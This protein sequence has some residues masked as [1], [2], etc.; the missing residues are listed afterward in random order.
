MQTTAPSQILPSYQFDTG[1]TTAIPSVVSCMRTI[2]AEAKAGGLDVMQLCRESK[3]VSEEEAAP[4]MQKLHDAAVLLFLQWQ[5]ARQ[6][7]LCHSV[8]ALARLFNG[9]TK[10]ARELHDKYDLF[11]RRHI[12]QLAEAL[13]DIDYHGAFDPCEVAAHMDTAAQAHTHE[14]AWAWVVLP[15]FARQQ[16]G[17]IL[18]TK[19]DI[20]GIRNPVVV[21]QPFFLAGMCTLFH[22]HGQ[23]WAF[24]RPL[25]RKDGDNSHLNSLWMPR[26]ADNPFPLNLLELAEYTNHGVAIVPPRLIHG[27]SRKRCEPRDIP[28]MKAL[29]ADPERCQRFIAETRFGELA[30]LHIYC[31]HVPLVHQFDDCPLVQAEEEFFIEYDMIVFDHYQESVWCGGGGS[32]PLRMMSFGT[33]GEHCGACFIEDDPRKENL[34]PELV[35]QWFVKS[36]APS[37]IRYQSPTHD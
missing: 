27:I 22:T 33:T 8:L 10:D 28:T 34:D 9:I 37:L 21:T 24:S 6:T 30:C 7:P 19:V 15:T 26:E 35:S 1:T 16:Y 31:P 4:H 23:N 32:W 5:K 18:L 36:P 25:G 13:S 2:L 20:P 3:V 29:L 14:K 17:R 12:D 11:D